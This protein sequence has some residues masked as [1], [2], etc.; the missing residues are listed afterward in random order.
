MTAIKVYN[1]LT[2]QK[3]VF[4]PRTPQ[5]VS[6]YVC[7]VTP[8]SNTHLGH[9]RPSVVWDVIK[10][11]FRSQGYKTVHVQNFTD[12]DDQIIERALKEGRPALEISNRYI[13]EYLAGMDAL[14]VE[15]ADFYPKVS[16]HM[17]QIIDFVRVLLEKNHAYQVQ[18]DVFFEVGSFA[19][20]GKLSKQKREELLAGTRFE[21]DPAKRDPAD[22]ALW[23]RAKPGEPSWESPWGLGRPGWHI[24]C[25][26]L[27]YEYLGTAFDFHGGGSDLI[28]PHHENEIAQS[29][30][31]TGS[32]LARYWVHNGMINFKAEKMSKSLGNVVSVGELVRRYPRELIRFYLL[33]TH[34]RSALEYYEGKL[35]E[36]QKGWSRLQGAV[37]NLKETL[38]LTLNR[39]ELTT[40]EKKVLERIEKMD[41]K[42][43]G[44]LADDFNTALALG[45]LFEL[46][47][48]IN[49]YQHQGGANPLVLGR[50][51][52]L[53]ELYSI[54]VL[55]VVG[56]E[57]SQEEGL[58]DPLLDLLL[59][60]RERL[61]QEK[62]FTL[63]DKIRE[64]LSALGVLVEDTP[65]G[66]RWK[67]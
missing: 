25:S 23:K 1:T 66:P 36:M 53:F 30:A 55:G 37:Q 35:E 11:F 39:P 50:A 45:V 10:R 47:R 9:A 41:Q 42:L 32:P 14:G 4:V 27:S 3:E 6:I 64:D 59:E 28:F 51:W 65:Q 17:E 29:E 15:R 43:L 56:S 22:F 58:V 60:L 61:R 63:A 62:N 26:A 34:Y 49:A 40:S 46:V 21:I 44:A 7:G 8:Y 52:D 12:V 54:N 38:E 18:G 16:E 2:Q 5:E 13:K 57:K 67:V 24:E 20:Y 33:S 19:E 31:A 48:E